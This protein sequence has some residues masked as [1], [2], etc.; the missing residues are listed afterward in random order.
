ME[1]AVAQ[2]LLLQLQVGHLALGAAQA[3]EGVDAVTRLQDAVQ[4]PVGDDDAAAVVA[5]L[6]AA[7]RHREQLGPPPGHVP[8]F[9]G[10]MPAVAA[11]PWRE[12]D[13]GIWEIRGERRAFMY[14]RLM[15]WVA[16]DRG[17]RLAE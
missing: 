3:G 17:I 4:D 2:V 16:L 13:R 14:S 6:D 8:G 9:P 7:Y 5:L 10:Q 11:R 12:P 1:P 15:C